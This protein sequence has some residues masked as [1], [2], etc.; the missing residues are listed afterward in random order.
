M[1]RMVMS[2]NVDELPAA[3]FHYCFNTFGV[4]MH[5]TSMKWSI[6]VEIWLQK[7]AL[8]SMLKK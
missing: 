8:F 4:D 2:Q 7:L 6:S 3:L 5:R 1:A